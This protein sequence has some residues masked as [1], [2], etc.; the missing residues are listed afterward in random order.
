M[1]QLIQQ[2][3]GPKKKPEDLMEKYFALPDEM[4]S[5]FISFED[6]PTARL[7]K[8]SLSG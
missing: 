6:L 4:P 1:T 2:G 7:E 8:F 3:S 5:R